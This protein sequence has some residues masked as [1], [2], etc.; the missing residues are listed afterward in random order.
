MADSKPS[1]TS[2]TL[3]AS[4][5]VALVPLFSPTVAAYIS[6]NPA[7]VTAILGLVFGALRIVTKGAVTIT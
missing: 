5:I 7:M 4:A 6:A 1:W 2:K 3:W